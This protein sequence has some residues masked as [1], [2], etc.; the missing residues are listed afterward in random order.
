MADIQ[1]KN[2]VAD[3]AVRAAVSSHSRLWEDNRYVYPV[4]SRR[5]KGISIGV[6]LN[7]DK[8]CNFDCIYCQVDRTIAPKFRDVDLEI[9]TSELHQLLTWVHDD[10]LFQRPPFTSVPAHLKRVNDIAFSGDGEPTSYPG[11]R[12]VVRISAETRNSFGLQNV[13]LVVITNGTLFHRPAVREA[14]AYLGENNGEIWAKLDAGTPDYYHKIERTKVSFAQIV[15]NIKS[16][17]KSRPIV[18]QSLFMN[19]DGEPP[20]ITEIDAYCHILS[21]VLQQGGRLKLIQLYTVARNPAES[22]VTPLSDE[23]MDRLG[24]IVREHIPAPVE[25]YYGVIN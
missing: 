24:N 21:E 13:K 19:V 17:A 10:T 4:L 7:P 15:E 16:T 14:L 9:L 6:N 18:I 1:D 2:I 12:D 20:P 25:V 3:Q 22:I 11:F 5:S 23:S 8:I